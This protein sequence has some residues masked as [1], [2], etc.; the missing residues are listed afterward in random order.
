LKNPASPG[1]QAYLIV[2]GD[3]LIGKALVNTLRAETPEVYATSRRPDVRDP[4]VVSLDLSGNP[5]DLFRDDRIREIAAEGRLT[6]FMSAA[7]TKIADCEQD[8]V[9]TRLV[10]VTNTVELGEKL[11]AAGAKVVFMSS[12]AIFSG[13]LPFPTETDVP[14]P[15]NN[16]GRQKVEAEHTLL[17]FHSALPDAPPLMIVRLTKVVDRSAPLIAGWIESL[18]AGLPIR[19]FEDRRLSPISLGHTVSNL[20]A[21]GKAG[22]TGI[23]HV[24]GTGDL[25]YYEF[26]RL[27]ACSLV[28][29]PGLVSPVVADSSVIGLVHQHSALGATAADKALALR[30]EAPEAAARSLVS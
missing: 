10:N 16:Y 13:L 18:R 8:P 9:R 3:G 19:A 17:H 15:N 23:Y 5:D 25:S 1:K 11:L 6:V 30:P 26:A 20:I 28:T 4:R 21:I 7:I 27:L 12:N 2:G 29:D 24:T 14:A 22:A